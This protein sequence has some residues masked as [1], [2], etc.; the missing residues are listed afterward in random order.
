MPK[1]IISTDEPEFTQKGESK[2][3]SLFS[4]DTHFTKAHVW[5]DEWSFINNDIVSRN[6]SYQLQYLEFLVHLYDEYEI[7][8][9]MKAHLC[10]NILVGVNSVVEASLYVSIVDLR[11]RA[12]LDG[13]WRSDYTALLGQAYNEY[14]MISR[15]LWHFFHELRKER[16]NLHLQSLRER[17]YEYYTIEKA[18]DALEKLEQLRLE[19]EDYSSDYVI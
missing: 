10:K 12:N 17:E 15:D 3:K 1:L 13:D 7:Y 8:L 18:N 5:R 16:N 6:I 14:Q 2:K 11:K 4:K 9:S 19:L